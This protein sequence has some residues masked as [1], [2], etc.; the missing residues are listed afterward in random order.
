MNLQNK[1]CKFLWAALIII[2]LLTPEK[3]YSLAPQSDLKK[4]A[5]FATTEWRNENLPAE[6]APADELPSWLRPVVQHLEPA[7]TEVPEIPAPYPFPNMKT[8]AGVHEPEWVELSLLA[9]SILEECPTRYSIVSLPDLRKNTFERFAEYR[10]PITNER[11]LW[12]LNNLRRKGL[13]NNLTDTPITYGADERLLISVPARSLA[14]WAD[15]AAYII[16][17]LRRALATGSVVD[18]LK[19]YQMVTAQW[20]LYPIEACYPVLRAIL[21][22]EHHEKMQVRDAIKKVY[23]PDMQRPALI[24]TI[25]LI[26]DPD[27]TARNWVQNQTPSLAGRNI[28][29]AA[30]EISLLAGGLGR[31]MQYHGDGM[32]KLGAN[33]MYIEPMYRRKKDGSPLDYT[34]DLPI[35]VRNL[36]K[37]IKQ[38]SVKVQGRKV[39]FEVWEG[40]NDNGVPVRFIHDIATPGHLPYCD[41]LY[42]YSSPENPNFVTDAEFTEF[43]SKATR[44]LVRYLETDE[45]KKMKNNWQPPVVDVN[46]GQVLSTNAWDAILRD[47]KDPM[48]FFSG[49]THTYRNRIIIWDFRVGYEY[50][51]KAGVPDE[52]KWLFLR[53]SPEGKPIWDFTSAG[54]R[55]ATIAAK[56]VSAIHVHEMGQNDPAV[57]LYA[58]TNGDNRVY[59]TTYFRK[60]LHELGIPDGENKFRNGTLSPEEIGRIKRRAKEALGLN[61]DQMVV[62]YSGRLVDEKAAPG[63][64]TQENVE[65]M[66]KQ[67]IQVVLYGNVQPYYASQKLKAN[68]EKIADAVNAKGYPGKFVFKSKFD[69]DE[70]LQLLPAADILALYSTRGTGAAEYTEVDVSSNGG[71]VL[72]PPYWE[73]IIGK[74]GLPV[75]WKRLT[76]N[77]MVPRDASPDAFRELIL[78]AD[79]IFKERPAD[80][81]TLESNSFKLSGIL[82][83]L[84][85]SAGYL[86]RWAEGIKTPAVPKPRKA[87]GELKR[88]NISNITL[89]PV[90][91]G[92][93]VTKIQ[94]GF[95]VS[96][97]GNVRIAVTVDLRIM[98]MFKYGKEDILDP[99]LVRVRLADDF[100]KIIPLKLKEA[101]EGIAVFEADV[102]KFPFEGTLDFTCGLWW[103][104]LPLK[105]TKGPADAVLRAIERHIREVG[106]D[107]IQ[108]APEKRDVY[109]VSQGK[110]GEKTF[111]GTYIKES[112]IISRGDKPVV[113]EIEIPWNMPELV[114]EVTPV[115]HSDIFGEWE[116]ARADQLLSS[117]VAY[118]GKKCVWRI[119]FIPKQSGELTFYVTLKSSPDYKIWFSPTGKNIKVKREEGLSET[120]APPA[121]AGELQEKEYGTAERIL[122]LVFPALQ[123]MSFA[124]MRNADLARIEQEFYRLPNGAQDKRAL[125]D[126]IGTIVETYATGLPADIKRGMTIAAANQLLSAPMILPPVRLKTLWDQLSRI[127]YAGDFSEIVRALAEAEGK[128]IGTLSHE[129]RAVL[130]LA[131][132]DVP[133]RSAGIADQKRYHGRVLNNILQWEAME[134]IKGKRVSGVLVQDAGDYGAGFENFLEGLARNSIDIA[135][136][137]M[138]FTLHGLTD[139]E[140]VRIMTKKIPHVSFVEK[141]EDVPGDNIVYLTRVIPKE[142]LGELRARGVKLIERGNCG[143]IIELTFALELLSLGSIYDAEYK[144]NADAVALYNRFL[145]KLASLGIVTPEQ[146][147][148]TLEDIKNLGYIKLPKVEKLDQMWEEMRLTETYA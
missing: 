50:L 95:Q 87:V 147:A 88:E 68:Y 41:I 58:E 107:V 22:M 20:K 49:V 43:F 138:V 131:N 5:D 13:L 27:G 121:G 135:A 112:P 113:L 76:G 106:F 23:L 36:R 97:T 119:A 67:G 70:Q 108:Y 19:E 25:L 18:I 61:P 101:K 38:L 117:S 126:L 26:L 84:P 47:T 17:D 91:K 78:F 102:D 45:K 75:N 30:A 59:S 57:D 28:Y 120:G 64:F 11:F 81:F 123:F 141:I 114:S 14:V 134:G 122:R 109:F 9:A 146:I 115:L 86:R 39:N 37:V 137:R 46:D 128:K 148:A 65:E 116:D 62:A 124:D 10:L 143:P 34:K 54:L 144:L 1:L 83:A 72:S 140:R 110:S 145:Q 96:G 125:L 73:G 24:D 12:L 79:T 82:E 48:I 133:F 42:T 136:V 60:F 118:D 53:I 100:G 2:A 142:K 111:K 44:E 3:I 31:V 90:G 92:M 104:K 85:T 4:I 21:S 93:T 6:S 98:D 132:K 15:D 69:I 8:G 99:E 52:W 66:L 63:Y 55:A 56:G 74:Q 33:I 7:V 130:N 77:T 32:R 71:L 103:E 29:F 16:G 51:Q 139:A 35:P 127:G 89:L 129:E 105:I 94:N 40:I 80:F